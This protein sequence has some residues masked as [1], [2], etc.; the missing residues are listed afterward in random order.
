M[1]VNVSS[2]FFVSGRERVCSQTVRPC[3]YTRGCSL[4]A[5]KAVIDSKRACISMQP[6]AIAVIALLFCVPQTIDKMQFT[7]YKS[8]DD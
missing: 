6:A 2:Q 5:V 4:L 1:E 8:R 7:V 3:S